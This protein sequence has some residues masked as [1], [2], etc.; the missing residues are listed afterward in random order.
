[1]LEH[2]CVNFLVQCPLYP[3]SKWKMQIE[4]VKTESG[5]FPLPCNGCDMMGGD[6]KCEQCM[7]AVTLMFYNQPDIDVSQPICP[8]MPEDK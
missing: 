4:L 7:A 2:R 1:M 5:W 8:K 3:F 6:P